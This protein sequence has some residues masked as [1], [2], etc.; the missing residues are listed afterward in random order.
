MKI[1]LVVAALL[2]AAVSSS[3]ILLT[4]RHNSTKDWYETAT[5]YQIYPRSF[6]DSD[7]DG[8]GDIKGKSLNKKCA[9]LFT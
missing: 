8:V 1:T 5:F 7:G 3:S 9:I 6:A 2:V 4:P